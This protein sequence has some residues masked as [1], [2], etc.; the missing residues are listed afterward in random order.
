MPESALL[1]CQLHTILGGVATATKASADI[2]D[3][4]KEWFQQVEARNGSEDLPVEETGGEK[5]FSFNSWKLLIANSSG[6]MSDI[7]ATIA[8]LTVALTALRQYSRQNIRIDIPTLSNIWQSV[9]QA[10][11]N[12]ELQ[13]TW[14]P[15]RS[16][17]GFLSVPLCSIITNGMIDEL[18]RFHVWLPDGK[19][20]NH[21]LAIHSHQPFAQSWILAGE[22]TDHRYE[23][24][25]VPQD[26]NATH[27]E[28]E[29]SWNTVDGKGPS[30]QYSAHQHSSVVASTGRLVHTRETESSVHRRNDSYSIPTGAFHSSQVA[31]DAHHA[32]LFYFDSSRGFIKDAPLLGPVRG[33]PYTQV[34]DPA[35]ETPQSLERHVFLARNWEDMIEVGRE[36]ARNA[37]WEQALREFNSALNWCDS[38]Q[39]FPG[40]KR[41]K[42]LVFG[43]LGS[44]NRRFGRYAVAVDFL[45]K[46][47][48]EL[49][50][51]P[52]Q[53][54]FDGELGVVYRHMGRLEDAKRAF[55]SQYKTVKEAG[56]D[57]ETCRAIGNLGMVNY[58]LSE[59]SQEPRLLEVAIEQLEERVQRCQAIKAELE[60]G[61]LQSA[62]VSQKSRQIE[63]WTTVGLTRLAICLTAKNDTEEAFKTA[64]Q[65]LEHAKKT[66]DPTVVAISRFFYGRAFDNRGDRVEA[67]R[68]FNIPDACTPA[69][70]FCKEPSEEHHAYLKY[71]V[72]A[73]ADMDLV[74]H[75]GYKALDYAVFNGDKISRNLVLEGLKRQFSGLADM[76]AM[77][78][79]RETEAELRKGY[80]E[81]FQE[82]LRPVLLAGGKD[83]IK[84]LRITY[85]EALAADRVKEGMFDP[86]KVI[87]Y[88][89]FLRHGKLP[90]SSDGLARTFTSNNVEDGEQYVIFFSYRW[91][92][93]MASPEGG[94]PDDEKHT[95]YN[96]A[97]QAVEEF[98]ESQTDIKPGNLRIWL[99]YACVDQD[100]PMKGVAALPMILAQCDAVIS[101]IDD[102]YYHRAWCSVEV[103]MIHTLKQSYNVHQWYEQPRLF[104]GT[105]K[106]QGA[107]RHGKLREAA[108][109]HVI[110]MADKKLSFEGDR[111][112]VLFLERQS[113]LLG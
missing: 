87:P 63:V 22:G 7:A 23:V 14:T 48:L 64:Q 34:R 60:A 73:G 69:I 109:G 86:F 67:L 26:A 10:L 76:N 49:R 97:K 66:G 88:L 5:A 92:N 45:K 52:E 37:E 25:P 93:P 31:P 90:R 40:V 44:T 112:K 65:A 50:N 56:L 89:D 78:A 62:S 33:E 32:T 42:G 104:A 77:L 75:H 30:K 51:S 43:E 35:G 84:K 16:A 105:G 70:A 61:N 4:V 28:Y 38:N 98:L 24:Q 113:K 2:I 59:Q 39:D 18:I 91:L 74:D 19:R 102:S 71:L 58:Q 107:M 47:C 83:C 11:K 80:R 15:S 72:D 79:Q 6:N 53:P 1:P 96:R 94:Y 99:D 55:E 9:S 95:Q 12:T 110:R 100:D 101:L 54:T 29:V 111:A 36:A 82:K 13:K 46:A 27:A 41:Y 20:G 3:Q 106:S 21:D 81:L 8:S 103:M 108:M 85:A 17:Q 57:F 68:Q